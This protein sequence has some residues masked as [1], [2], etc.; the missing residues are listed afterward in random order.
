MK[1]RIKSLV[2]SFCMIVFLGNINLASAATTNEIETV[3]NWAENNFPEFFPVHQATQMIDPW[4]FRFYPSTGI[5]TGVRDNQVFVLG[6]PWGTAN[7]TFIDTLPNLSAHI[8]ATNGNGSVPACSATSEI[9][10]GMVM[11]QSGNV[12]S[13]S[14]NGQCIPLPANTSF[15][16]PPAQSAPSGISVFYNI[17]IISSQVTGLTIDVPGFPNPFDSIAENFS[18][19][20]I[21]A[22]ENATS[23]IINSNVCFD[24]TSQ[25][26]DIPSGFGVTVTPPVTFTTESSSNNQLVPDC[27]ATGAA[28]VNDAFTG[29]S[30]FRDATT[31][32]YIKT[33]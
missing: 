29:E 8:Q 12:V 19:C 16:E 20:V 14:T 5:Y 17:N 33:N 6:G 3:F 26:Q 7:P 13:I 10:A 23:L 25:F 32:N 24:M 21:N 22:S 28:S 30:W 9:P 31:G 1:N 18:S 11:T 15:C 27:F 2:L 4:A